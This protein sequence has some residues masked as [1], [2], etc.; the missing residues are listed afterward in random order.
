MFLQ[1]LATST[2][3]GKL[4]DQHVHEIK[5]VFNLFDKQEEPVS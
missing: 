5:A 4:T 2:I 1:N 3:V